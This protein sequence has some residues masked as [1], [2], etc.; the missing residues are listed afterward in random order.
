MLLLTF[1]ESSLKDKEFT[2]ATK[3][4]TMS[5]MEDK[6]RIF[7]SIHSLERFSY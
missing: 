4:K 7:L 6:C 3:D 1:I 2:R 5:T